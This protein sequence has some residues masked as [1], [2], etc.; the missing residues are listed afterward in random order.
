MSFA[1]I[2]NDG[3]AYLCAARNLWLNP[4]KALLIAPARAHPNPP[5]GGG[6][7]R[8][9]GSNLATL[10]FCPWNCSLPLQGWRIRVGAQAPARETK[11]K[12]SIRDCVRHSECVAPSS[13]NQA[14][15]QV[16]DF[17]AK[18]KR[19]ACSPQRALINPGWIYQSFF[20]KLPPVWYY[21]DCNSALFLFNS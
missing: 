19:L 13:I 2:I 15:T 7:E 10:F 18:W 21:F 3:V 17:E 9:R 5:P 12:D 4:D 14:M 6:R 8:E 16:I 11:Q 20:N 1:W